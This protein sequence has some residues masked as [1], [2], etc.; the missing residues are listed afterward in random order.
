[1]RPLIPAS[2]SVLL[3]SVGCAPAAPPAPEIDLEAERARILQA[4]RDWYEAYTASDDPVSVFVDNLVPEGAQLLPPDAPLAVGRDAIRETIAALEA[5]PGFSIVWAPSN[6]DV[7]AGGDMAYTVGTYEMGLE[8]P[9][10]Q[11]VVI[12]GKYVTVWKKQ[13]DGSWRVAVD[14]FNADGP[15]APAEDAG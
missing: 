11:P 7:G 12:A 13:D 6:A 3:L 14:M 1:M 10:G 5:M 4:D 2:L 9:D 15:P 8:G